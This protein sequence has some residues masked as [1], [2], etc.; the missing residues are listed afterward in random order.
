MIFSSMEYPG[1]DYRVQVVDTWLGEEFEP[2]D[3]PKNGDEIVYRIIGEN[4]QP[5]EQKTEIYQNGAWVE[6]GGGGGG[7]NIKK[8]ADGDFTVDNAPVEI[9]YEP[10][11]EQVYPYAWTSVT[12]DGIE[13]NYESATKRF[14]KIQDGKKY[15]VQAFGGFT[16]YVLRVTNQRNSSQYMNGTY[17]VVIMGGDGMDITSNGIVNV[18]GKLKA[19][20]DVKPTFTTWDVTISCDESLA[21]KVPFSFVMVQDNGTVTNIGG[22][23][24]AV[25]TS[26]Y[27]A[28]ELVGQM[29][30]CWTE[31]GTAIDITATNASDINKSSS[32]NHDCVAAFIKANTTLTV[33][34]YTP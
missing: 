1:K 13:L 20:V 5:V 18:D 9:Q 14:T 27:T 28:K 21:G 3:N 2:M 10:G 26:P 22:L 34:P 8:I 33:V 25:P 16:N 32:L 17:H 4:G 11:I 15:W 12:V 29:C 24:S 6:Q 19:N 23:N 31:D 30:I 7:S